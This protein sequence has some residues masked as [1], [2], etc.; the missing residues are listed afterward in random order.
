MTATLPVAGGG[1]GHTIEDEGSPLTARSSLNFVGGGVRAADS[2]GKTVVTVP[3]L[4]W[5][6]ITQPPYN[7]VPTQKAYVGVVATSG[8]AIIDCAGASFDASDIG[9]PVMVTGAGAAGVTLVSTVLSVQSA[10]R[11]T[12]AAN[13]S[14]N[15]PASSG[16]A[17]GA[18]CTAAIQSAINDA[19]ALGGAT[20]YFPRGN[21]LLLAALQTGSVTLNGSAGTP[22][23]VVNYSGQLLFPARPLTSSHIT[24]RFL[25]ETPP[26]GAQWGWS[27]TQAATPTGSILLSSL[28]SSNVFDVIGDVSGNPFTANGYTSIMGYFDEIT[29][30]VPQSSNTTAIKGRDLAG[31]VLEH[32]NLDIFAKATPPAADTGKAVWCPGYANSGIVDLRSVQIVGYGTGVVL[33]EHA[34]LDS[35]FIDSTVTAITP[36]GNAL[37]HPV[38]LRNTQAAGCVTALKA[39]TSACNIVGD[40]A[41]EQA[42]VH[43]SDTFGGG[44][45]FRGELWVIPGVGG[46]GITV[47]GQVYQLN[48]RTLY[49]PAGPYG[50]PIRDRFTRVTESASN[51][52]MTDRSSHYYNIGQATGTWGIVSGKAKSTGFGAMGCPIPETFRSYAV[53]GKILLGTAACIGWCVRAINSNGNSI[54]ALMQINGATK[55]VVIL[56]SSG[57]TVLATS[58]A[59]TLTAG[60]TVDF[61]VT[62]EQKVPGASATVKA[63]LAGVEV[64]SYTLSGAE[65]TTFTPNTASAFDTFAGMFYDM[66]GG[67]DDHNS[68]WVEMSVDRL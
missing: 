12:M 19:A 41:C 39:S 21:Y 16:V 66:T 24:I 25:G 23:T 7:A 54:G 43:I 33:G 20:I 36:D 4:G 61:A 49:A 5:L 53:S 42:Q 59:V 30:R 15:A 60:T 55:N 38:T 3:A 62:W 14:T 35:V 68:R 27:T 34:F 22:G 8:S 64:V 10:T 11:L 2:G 52:D 37:A 31:I 17:V 26:G 63:L 18:D 40:L 65:V 29:V 44:G 13:A 46:G 58:G 56:K 9:K 51:M 48:V 28:M 6:D 50:Q 47:R 32:T 57:F 45:G 1:S 67:L